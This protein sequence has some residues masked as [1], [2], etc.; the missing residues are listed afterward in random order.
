[1]LQEEVKRTGTTIRVA[2][3]PTLGL[4]IRRAG[5]EMEAGVTVLETGRR[6]DARA[7]AA[8][9]AAGAG[10]VTVRRRLRGALR[11]TGNEIR[12]AGARRADARGGLR[13]VDGM[14]PDS[15]APY[16]GRL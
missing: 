5:S 6:L 3:R 10:S 16:R 14:P 2:T 1:M 11:V 15:R 8:C 7:I 9:A 13:G 4:T 12:T